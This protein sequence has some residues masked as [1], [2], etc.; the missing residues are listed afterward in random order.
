M[1]NAKPDV[2]PSGKIA[3]FEDDKW[4][5]LLGRQD[6]PLVQD[7]V[8]K[9]FDDLAAAF[10]SLAPVVKVAKI[11]CADGDVFLGF[12]V[13]GRLIEGGAV[14]HHRATIVTMETAIGGDPKSIRQTLIWSGNLDEVSTWRDMERL[15]A[16]DAAPNLKSPSALAKLKQAA[17]WAHPAHV[18]LSKIAAQQDGPEWAALPEP[19]REL[20]E[21]G[22]IA[23]EQAYRAGRL[24]REAELG[25]HNSSIDA[26]TK[27][28]G[29][30]RKGGETTGALQ[31]ADAAK[32]R[33]QLAAWLRPVLQ[34]GFTGKGLGVSRPD[35]AIKVQADGPTGWKGKALS[36]IEAALKI[37]EKDGMINRPSPP[38]GRHPKAA[39]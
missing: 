2:P 22:W 1:P 18:W 16:L 32:A 4:Y 15:L 6:L 19:I 39:K 7:R 31:S 5:R 13:T 25:Q 14:D 38:K 12:R 30:A 24:M 37:L 27:V 8:F 35:L 9:T 34:E 3:G 10:P 23:I 26:A 11:P 28:R 21:R 29:G 20:F 17:A 33:V 36:T